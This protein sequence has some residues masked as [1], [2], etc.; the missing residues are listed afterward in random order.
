MI[1]TVMKIGASSLGK[2]VTMGGLALIIRRKICLQKC[3]IGLIEFIALVGNFPITRIRRNCNYS[4]LH[5]F[6]LKGHIRVGRKKSP[7][8]MIYS[9]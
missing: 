2:A 9:I 8:K 3:I 6:V 4:A 1:K 5:Q 7:I